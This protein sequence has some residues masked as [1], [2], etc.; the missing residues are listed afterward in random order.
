MIPPSLMVLFIGC[1]VSDVI[2]SDIIWQTLAKVVKE[3]SEEGFASQSLL[4][5]NCRINLSLLKLQNK[6]F[7]SRALPLKKH[8]NRTN[9]WLYLINTSDYAP[10]L[11]GYKIQIVWS[12]TFG[13][14]LQQLC[15]KDI[16]VVYFVTPSFPKRIVE[17]RIFCERVT[18]F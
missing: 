15:N 16:F 4:C 7:T 6:V 18:P 8:R 1:A 9:L 2:V 13:V 14:F 12:S 3:E 10:T 17:E 11:K 5:Y